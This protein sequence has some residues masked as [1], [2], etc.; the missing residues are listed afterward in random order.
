MRPPDLEIVRCGENCTKVSQKLNS[1]DLVFKV[2]F[3]PS[4]IGALHD[5]LV[6]F[7]G[8]WQFALGFRGSSSGNEKAS[9][10]AVNLGDFPKVNSDSWVWAGS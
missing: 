10:L 6:E 3:D 5:R 4:C 2:D 8:E 9:R 1:I 7:V